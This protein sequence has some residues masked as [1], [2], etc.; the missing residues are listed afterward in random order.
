MVTS[1]SRVT[2]PNLGKI[3]AKS[4]KAWKMS[5]EVFQGLEKSRWAFPSLGKYS[6]VAVEI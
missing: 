1:Y 2:F 4:S 6:S 5:R 3:S